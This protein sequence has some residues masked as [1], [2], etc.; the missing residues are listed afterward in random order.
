MDIKQFVTQWLEKNLTK[1]IKC[2][3]LGAVKSDTFTQEEI[4][5][6]LQNRNEI[7]TRW[8]VVCPKCFRTLAEWDCPLHHETVECMYCDDYEFQ[9]TEGLQPI[10]Y[11][12]K[13][14]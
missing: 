3:R 1:A 10:F 4:S 7:I 12:N 8:E 9:S 13:F 11:N 5:K 2:F 14:H 6:E